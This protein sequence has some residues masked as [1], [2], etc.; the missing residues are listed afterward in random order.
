M[1]NNDASNALLPLSQDSRD[2]L[3][4]LLEEEMQ[5]RQATDMRQELIGLRAELR[6]LRLEMPQVVAT[7]MRTV[8]CEF[9]SKPPDE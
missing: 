6:S 1:N 5:R 9:C 7:A 4:R 8:L 2:E 3:N